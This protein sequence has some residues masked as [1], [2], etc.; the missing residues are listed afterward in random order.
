VE[1]SAPDLLSVLR[2]ELSTV[3]PSVQHFL[4]I[5]SPF[6]FSPPPR[7]VIFLNEFVKLLDMDYRGAGLVGKIC[8]VV[9]A[10]GDAGEV[11]IED[12]CKAEAELEHGN[13]C[14]SATKAVYGHRKMEKLDE[15]FPG[16]VVPK[17]R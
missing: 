5:F 17:K 13:H 14:T 2:K 10:R 11:R 3:S 1:T 9:S 15:T 7:L 6:S 8:D 12:C 16:R 4:A